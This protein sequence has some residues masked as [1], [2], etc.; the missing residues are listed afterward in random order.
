MF[1]SPSCPTLKLMMNYGTL[2]LTST[3]GSNLVRDTILIFE[4]MELILNLFLD[5]FEDYISPVSAAQTLL[6]SACKKRK[7]ML[8]K[9]IQLCVEIL[10][11]PNSNDKQKDGALHMVKFL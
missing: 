3:S 8:Q 11:N 10:T 6:H 5:I 2:I 9:T 1:S 4:E 7:D